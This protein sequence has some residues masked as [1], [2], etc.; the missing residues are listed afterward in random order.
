M[1]QVALLA[2]LASATTPLSVSMWVWHWAAFCAE[3]SWALTSLTASE[4]DQQARRKQFS[5]GTAT[6]EGSA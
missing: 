2:S 5:S 6:A 3:V 4:W 1:V